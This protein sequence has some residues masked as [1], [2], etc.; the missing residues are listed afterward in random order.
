MWNVE[1]QEVCNRL[2]KIDDSQAD[3]PEL[4]PEVKSDL[5]GVFTAWLRTALIEEMSE[6]DAEGIFAAVEV[7]LADASADDG[8]L[9]SAIEVVAEGG[10]PRCA[11]SFSEQWHLSIA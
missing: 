1:D 11:E 7:I 5:N 8:A 3:T 9:A 6:A 10:A 2:A 4:K